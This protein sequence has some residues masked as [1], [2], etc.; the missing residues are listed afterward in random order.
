MKYLASVRIFSS[1]IGALATVIGVGSGC[2]FT[3]LRTRA[4]G[5]KINIVDIES[6][7]VRQNKEVSFKLEVSYERYHS[8]RSDKET[9][10]LL[11]IQ[12]TGDRDAFVKIDNVI[13]I[14]VSDD[15][16]LR[17]FFLGQLYSSFGVKKIKKRELEVIELDIRLPRQVT[18]LHG[19]M[20]LPIISTWDSR[21][22]ETLLL[23]EP[24]KSFRL[25]FLG[26]GVEE[27]LNK[28]KQVIDAYKLLKKRKKIHNWNLVKDSPNY[29]IKLVS[30]FVNSIIEKYKVKK[31]WFYQILK[32]SDD[33]LPSFLHTNVYLRQQ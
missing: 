28:N 30:F 27:V 32:D 1:L 24:M 25:Y 16:G 15:D 7:T 9:K 20:T 31:D 2:V 21:G 4:R 8:I 18:A 5:P 3:R 29:Y 6:G 10:F 13:F 17:R 19:W 11:F 22:R 33:K 12:N 26:E 23:I 14:G